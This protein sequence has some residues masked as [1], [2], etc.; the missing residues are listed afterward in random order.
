MND[1]FV[2]VGVAFVG[3]LSVLTMLLALVSMGL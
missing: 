1:I 2:R 3:A